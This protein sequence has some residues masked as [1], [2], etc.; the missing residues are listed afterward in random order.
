MDQQHPLK[1]RESGANEGNNRKRNRPEPLRNLSDNAND[2]YKPFDNGYNSPLSSPIIKEKIESVLHFASAP[3]VEN[4][5]AEL[6]LYE[7]WQTP[8]RTTPPENLFSVED[9]QQ[10]ERE[11]YNPRN[12]LLQ[13]LVDL[14]ET[15]VPSTI[16]PKISLVGENTV[17]ETDLIE[18]FEHQMGLQRSVTL[19]DANL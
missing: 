14:V 2:E 5:T 1:P 11:L 3:L 6:L 17:S 4:D 15:A 13:N 8:T 9:I 18:L 19:I 10:R 12:H 16:G 7:T